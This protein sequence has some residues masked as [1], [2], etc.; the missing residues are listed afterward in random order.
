[1]PKYPTTIL[2]IV[3]DCALIET[4]PLFHSYFTQGVVPKYL[5]GC[6]FSGGVTRPVVTA[7]FN[8]FKYAV[9]LPASPTPMHV[10]SYIFLEYQ[11]MECS[12]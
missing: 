9:L 4:E 10:A 7:Q 3:F 8:M 12:L 6:F 2:I 5:N 1:M 11:T